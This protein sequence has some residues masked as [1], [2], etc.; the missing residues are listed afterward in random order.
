MQ[1]SRLTDRGISAHLQPWTLAVSSST[2][3]ALATAT[4]KDDM[5]IEVSDGII[6]DIYPSAEGKS[7]LADTY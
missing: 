7:I 6:S 2:F 5:T 3:L 4:T 1:G